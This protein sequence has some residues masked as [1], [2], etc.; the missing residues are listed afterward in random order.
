INLAIKPAWLLGATKQH[1]TDTLKAYQP[2]LMR[3]EIW[4][5]PMGATLVS[6]TYGSDPQS[7]DQA[8]K[9]FEQSDPRGKKIFVFGGLRSR[10]ATHAN[11]LKRIAES[12]NRSRPDT[13]HLVGD[14]D[15]GPLRQALSIAHV[16]QSRQ[17]PDA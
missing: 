1:L 5:A 16:C 14:Q 13:L 7:V 2:D 8:L 17:F 3:T 10:G 6:E 12:I 15:F 9:H 11:D 4:H